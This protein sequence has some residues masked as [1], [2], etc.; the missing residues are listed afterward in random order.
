MGYVETQ[1]CWVCVYILIHSMCVGH[2]RDIFGTILVSVPQRV[3]QDGTCSPVHQWGSQRCW[4]FSRDGGL[5]VLRPA[6]AACP[7][8][9]ALPPFSSPAHNKS[10]VM[11]VCRSGLSTA[12]C[13]YHPGSHELPF[14][15]LA[16]RLISL[17]V[18]ASEAHFDFNARRLPNRK[19]RKPGCADLQSF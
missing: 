12:S 8:C 17:P 2:V 3:P 4:L 6:E 1:L 14:H 18:W 13:M 15:G 5:V 9:L 16:N 19:M 10:C 7:H 11:P